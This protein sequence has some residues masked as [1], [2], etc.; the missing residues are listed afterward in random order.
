MDC[1]PYVKVVPA[2]TWTAY[3]Y[4]YQV[5]EYKYEYAFKHYYEWYS[6]RTKYVLWWCGTDLIGRHAAD[7]RL[8]AAVGRTVPAVHRTS[9]AQIT[10][11]VVQMTEFF[12]QP[13]VN[14]EWVSDLFN[15]GEKVK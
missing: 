14:K 6:T 5:F 2:N 9:L 12:R 13:A 10:A 8:D 11:G 15:D 3:S 7:H 4:S 1:T